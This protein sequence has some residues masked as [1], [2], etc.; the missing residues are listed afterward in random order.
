MESTE[1]VDLSSFID[2]T[3]TECLNE[4]KGHAFVHAMAGMDTMSL[5]SDC[6]EQL[7]INIYFTTPVKLH[8]VS[9]TPSP[10]LEHNPSEIAFFPNKA[11][12]DF[13]EC[14]E[15]EEPVDSF[16]LDEP[17]EEMP[18]EYVKYQSVKSLVVFIS[19]N[20]DEE[21]QTEMGKLNLYG[22]PVSGTVDIS[23]LGKKEES[24]KIEKAKPTGGVSR[25]RPKKG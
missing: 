7:L 3:K 16:T 12:L 10:N 24:K 19:Q 2:K 6:D 17:G 23:K 8:H 18:L 21:E 4:Q 25:A 15:V 11:P 1:F 20:F 14:E 13:E 5:R 9:I 22:L